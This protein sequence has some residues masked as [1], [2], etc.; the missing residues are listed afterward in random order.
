MIVGLLCIS[1]LPMSSPCIICCCSKIFTRVYKKTPC[2]TKEWKNDLSS[3]TGGGEKPFLHD[4]VQNDR[5]FAV[6]PKNVY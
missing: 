4:H 3:S 6:G 2:C 5:C 1:M